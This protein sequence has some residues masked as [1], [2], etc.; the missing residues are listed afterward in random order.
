MTGSELLQGRRI[1]NTSRVTRFVAMAAS[2]AMTAGA[3]SAHAGQT[4]PFKPNSTDSYPFTRTTT[5]TNKDS[6]GQ[7]PTGQYPWIQQPNDYVQD[8]PATEVRAVPAARAAAIKAKWEY[9]RAKDNLYQTVDFLREDFEDANSTRTA[10]DA[11]ESA[12]GELDTIRA[13]VLGKLAD[14]PKYKALRTLRDQA[15]EQVQ[16]L[17]TDHSTPPAQV[18]AA[19]QVK[20]D[21]ARKL[22]EM[23]HDAL[24]NDSAYRDAKARL[25]VAGQDVARMRTAFNKGIRRDPEFRDAR[26]DWEDARIDYAVATTYRDNVVEARNIALTYAYN[27]HYYDYYKYLHMGSYGYP[28]NSYGGYYG[29]YNYSPTPTYSSMFRY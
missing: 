10:K 27:L 28:F 4:D 3:F 9:W 17:R 22:S 12:H 8:Y 18:A 11:Q 6:S 25:T 15:D 29:G 21:Y 5:T 16:Q 20:M 26:R 13:R 2:L 24:L 7:I 19:A 1:M 23:E 14:D